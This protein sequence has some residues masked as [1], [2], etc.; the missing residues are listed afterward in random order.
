[1]DGA[2]TTTRPRR[3]GVG[4]LLPLIIAATLAVD[5]MARFLPLDSL[6]FQA[7]ECMTRYQEP[8][9]SFEANRQFRSNR[10]HGNLSN[11]GNLPSLREYRPQV[12][13]TDANGFRNAPGLASTAPDGIVVGDSFVAGYGISDE[14]TL[15]VQLSAATGLR[16]YNAGGP[17]AYLQTVRALKTKM[18]FQRGQVIVVW[19]ESE[20]VAQLQQAEALAQ[21]GDAKAGFMRAAFGPQ[22]ARIRALLRGWWYTSPAKIVAEKA[23]L[24][25]ADDRILPNVYRSRVVERHLTTGKPI[26][27]YPSDVDGFHSRRDVTEA[28]DF[29]VAL[30]AGLRQE[31][32]ASMVVLAPNKYTVYE[33]LLSDRQQG[34]GDAV[35]PLARLEAALKSRGIQALDLTP[36][37][38]AQARADL[39][40]GEYLYWLDDTHWNRHGIEMAVAALRRT[41]FD[42]S[43]SQ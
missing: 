42:G 2:R 13:T 18:G 30:S 29:L 3:I 9:S 38:A 34:P 19:T 10:T 36:S 4:R 40:T 27:F 1:M 31:G 15:P 23:F 5:V 39:P 11:M 26:L 41:W 35:H 14:E 16:F 12:F 7:W 32:L 22:G 25:I 17:Y 21:N 24:S 33:P 37:F 20:S 6:C 28:T 8:G 43:R